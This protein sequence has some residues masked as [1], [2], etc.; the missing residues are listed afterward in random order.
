MLMP[1]RIKERKT[2]RTSRRDESFDIF[3][4]R[5]SH[6]SSYY[7][8][9]LRRLRPSRLV[10]KDKPKDLFSLTIQ[11]LKQIKRKKKN[12]LFNPLSNRK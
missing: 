12:N 6:V 3:S 5:V 10:Y 9:L 7:S 2:K 1:N 11:F 4:R 8:S